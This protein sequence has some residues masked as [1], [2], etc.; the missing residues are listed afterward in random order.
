[1]CIRDRLSP[2]TSLVGVF[3]SSPEVISL[4]KIAL[5]AADISKVNAVISLPPSFPLNIKSSSEP[6]DLI[7]KFPLTFL[8]LPIAVPASLK[9]TSAPSASKTISSALS[10]TIFS[11]AE[12]CINKLSS[13]SSP[14]KCESPKFIFPAK[15][16][17]PPVVN[18]KAEVPLLALNAQL[19]VP[20]CM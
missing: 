18:K 4:L 10:I 6:S 15:V 17:S 1:M 7:T 12:L 11:P 5:P 16:A 9:T 2:T 13:L 20:L 8:N 14:I 19:S 3:I